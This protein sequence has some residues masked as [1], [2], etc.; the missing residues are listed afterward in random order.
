MS[1]A[2]NL[3]PEEFSAIFGKATVMGS[4]GRSRLCPVCKGWHRLDQPWP[5]NCRK[6]AP[7]RSDLAAPQ[8]APPFQEFMTGRTDTAEYIGSRNDKREFMERHELVEYDEGVRPDAVSDREVEREL[9]ADFKR[10]ME[11]DPLNRPPMERI[12]ETDTEGAG[13]ISMDAVEVAP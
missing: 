7:P 9:V 10:S 11:E 8:I 13:E 4:A 6:P 1:F 12:G 2:V 3:S 5:H